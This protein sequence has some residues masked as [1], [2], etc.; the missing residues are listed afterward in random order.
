MTYS[1]GWRARGTIGALIL[2]LVV[3]LP[4]YAL[5]AGAAPIDGQ[6]L[7]VCRSSLGIARTDR[8]FFGFYERYTATG[9]ATCVPRDPNAGNSVVIQIAMVAADLF[10][11]DPAAENANLCLDSETCGTHA[12]VWTQGLNDC[13][14]ANTWGKDAWGG[15]FDRYLS[16]GCLF[17]VGDALIPEDGVI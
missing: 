9:R 3:L 7:S 17:N 10:M 11:L 15:T 5:P 1:T 6:N 4:S 12:S 8:K 16:E 14:L 13:V 2:A